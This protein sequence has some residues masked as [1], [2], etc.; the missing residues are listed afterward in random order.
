MHDDLITIRII[1]TTEDTLVIPIESAK[2]NLETLNESLRENLRENL[3]EI[4]ETFHGILKIHREI[5]IV[6][7]LFVI[8]HM[9]WSLSVKMVT[10]EREE[11]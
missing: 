5:E 7:I 11:M 1:K 10:M 6:E 4:N 2:E 3:R 8:A 9:M